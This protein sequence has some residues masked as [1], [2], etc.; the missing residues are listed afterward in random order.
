[1]GD[2]IV[3]EQYTTPAMEIIEFESED[4]ITTSLINGDKHGDVGGEGDI[5][6]P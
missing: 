5:K 3:K 2:T 4:V 6:I 1:M